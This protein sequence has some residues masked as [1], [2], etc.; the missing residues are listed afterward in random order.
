MSFRAHRSTRSLIHVAVLLVSASQLH[1]R[2]TSPP[3]LSLT[4]AD[5]TRKVYALYAQFA[6]VRGMAPLEAQ[7][8]QMCSQNCAAVFDPKTGATAGQELQNIG[9]RKLAQA[10]RIADRIRNLVN[11][12]ILSNVHAADSDL[13]GSRLSA[14][15]HDILGQASAG[16]PSVFVLRSAGKRTLIVFYVIGK[17]LAAGEG[18]SSAVLGAYQ[19][20]NGRLRFTGSVDAG[21]DGY[22]DVVARQLPSPVPNEIWLLLAGKASGANGPNTR[23][24]L[25]A[26]GSRGFRPVWMP[27]NA[28]GDFRIASI[29]GGFRIDGSYYRS[30]RPRH[31]LYD[32]GS[33]GVTLLDQRRP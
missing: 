28:W 33:D 32:L 21:M 15:L 8:R 2:S 29:P 24:R 7:A 11:A 18:A 31:D 12:Y 27:A 26:C 22:V 16:T 30:G 20:E 5:A 14:D 17:A 9:A 3:Q 23:F 13:D 25:V 4:K 10:N 1:A 6:S 19:A